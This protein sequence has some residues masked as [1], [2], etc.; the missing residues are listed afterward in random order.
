M[1]GVS[2]KY[3]AL[4]SAAGLTARA[5]IRQESNAASWTAPQTLLL[6]LL[7]YTCFLNGTIAVLFNLG[8]GMRLIGKSPTTG[9]V[10]VWSYFVFFGFH[11]PTWLYTSLHHL[12]DRA[13]KVPVATEVE[14]GW[15]VGG[16]YAAALGKH[17]A[18]VVDITCEFPEG[19]AATT[20][21]YLL[22]PCWDGVPPPPEALERAALFAAS[23][24]ASGD[25]LVHCAHGRGRS[26]TVMCACL[27]KADV[28]PN[29]EAALEAVKRHRR[30]AKLN[31]AMRAALAA[32][33]S[34][35]MDTTPS[36]ASAEKDLSDSDGPGWAL[37]PLRHVRAS[38]QRLRF[39]GRSKLK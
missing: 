32:W 27:V 34:Q 17:W 36:K 18:G 16:R 22:L 11:A 20:D 1:H 10:P 3:V 31:S 8:I 2:L 30:V 25:V 6:L 14:P 24:R 13:M 9:A 33:Q 5:V 28:H 39:Y 7:C 26:T 23:A 38:F 29:W 37:G 15:W 4:S 35:Y 19:C 12:K 21:Q